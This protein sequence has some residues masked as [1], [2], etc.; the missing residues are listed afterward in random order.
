VP[1]VPAPPPPDAEMVIG[2]EPMTVKGEQDA[3]PEQVA[4]VVA[5]FATWLGLLK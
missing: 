5:T 3:E 2:D 4:E 1:T